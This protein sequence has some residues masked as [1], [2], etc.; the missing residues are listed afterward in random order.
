MSKSRLIYKYYY[1][2][3]ETC[4]NYIIK[5]VDTIFDNMNYAEVNE[6]VQER[7]LLMDWDITKENVFLICYLRYI[8]TTYPF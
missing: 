5:I 1:Y 6:L 2:E 7:R 4:C 8:E 3:H